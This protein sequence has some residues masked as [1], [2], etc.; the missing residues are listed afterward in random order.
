[1]DVRV[2]IA[3]ARVAVFVAHEEHWDSLRNE[4]GEEKVAHLPFAERG[5]RRVIGRSF[6]TAI[7]TVILVIAIVILFAISVVVLVL[8]GDEVAEGKPIVGGD[9]ID[10]A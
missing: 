3:V 9:E 6:M 8:I 7:P 2:I 4:K 1:M 10:A 5:N